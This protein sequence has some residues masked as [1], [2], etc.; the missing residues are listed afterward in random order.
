MEFSEEQKEVI[1]GWVAEGC[2]LSEIQRRISDEFGKTMTYMDVR[3]LVIDLDVQ[4]KDESG[5][6]T[7][8]Q[9][10]DGALENAT[11]DSVGAEPATDGQTPDEASQTQ[12][13][14]GVMVELDKL[15]RPG[16]IISGTVVF[17]DGVKATWMLD[18]M[19][20][21]AMEPSQPDYR[22]SEEDNAAFVQALRD[23]V[24]K[25]GY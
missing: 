12:M 1:K 4:I 13:P 8:K 9:T 25:K 24:A 21:L 20:R 10:N 11:A 19:G 2:G 14:G 23:E 22:P 17:S 6:D 16:A 18:Q 5:A 15:V 3:F 7:A